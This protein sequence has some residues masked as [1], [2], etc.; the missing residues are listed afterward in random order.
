M[1][2][3]SFS[4]FGGPEVLEVIDASVPEPGPDQIRIAVSAAGVNGYDWKVRR[5]LMGGALPK[6]V[7][8]EVAGTVDAVGKNVS[9]IAVGDG[10]FGFAV[11]GGAAEYTL[12]AHYSPLPLGVDAVTAAG[13]PV[14]VE[15]AYRVLDLVGVA[16]GTTVLV[17]GASG[18]VGQTAVQV[19]V[20]R[21]AHVIGTASAAN[22]DFLRGLGAEPLVYGDGLTERVRALGVDPVDVAIDAGGGGVLPDLIELTGGTE[23]V[24][25][26]VD[27]EGAEA[28]GVTASGATGAYYGLDEIKA[29]LAQ[30]AYTPPKVRAYPLE[31]VGA[32]QQAAEAGNLGATKLVLTL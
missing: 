32:A 22:Q 9:D 5:G 6:R 27:F 26:I 23:H 17:S 7:G 1:R 10:V 8:L 16:S 2:A 15:T 29:L 18:G 3:I 12:S 14:V 28:L 19:A 21:G 31:Q 11:G 24:V 25:T 20:N 13:L 30:G 4:E